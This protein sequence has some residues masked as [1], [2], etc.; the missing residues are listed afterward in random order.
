MASDNNPYTLCWVCP[1]VLPQ[2]FDQV[3]GTN[4][5][6]AAEV[7]SPLLPETRAYAC[8]FTVASIGAK[9]EVPYFQLGVIYS[10]EGTQRYC[11]QTTTV[12][13]AYGPLWPSLF[14]I[15]RIFCA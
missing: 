8:N 7:W 4:A 15:I 6:L 1:T 11:F 10:T 14:R 13:L 5:A 3:H 12:G 9:K 2:V